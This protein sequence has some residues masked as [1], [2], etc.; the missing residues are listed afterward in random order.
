MPL[1]KLRVHNMQEEQIK[2]YAEFYKNYLLD[3][4][5]PFWSTHSVDWKHG[6]YF[7]CLDQKGHVYDTDKFIWLQARQAWTYSMLFNRVD[8]R[9][10]WLDIAE[11]GIQFLKNFGRDE[12]GQFYFSLTKEGTPLTY[13][14]NI[15]ADCF[16]ALAFAEHYKATGN[17][18]SKEIAVNTYNQFLKRKTNPKGKF[19]KSTGNRPMKSFGLS[20]MTAYL[21]V[22]LSDLIEGEQQNDIYEDCVHQILDVHYHPEHKVIYENVALDGSLLDTYDGR[23]INPGHGIEA[24]WFLMDLAKKLNRPEW[25]EKA[26]DICIELLEYGWDKKYGGIFYFMDSKKAPLQQLEWDQKLWWVHQEALIA[27]S[28][29]YLLTQRKDIWLW[30]QKVHDYAWSHFPDAENGEWF[31]YLNREGNPHL[32]LKGGKWKGCF[33]TPRAMY[34]CWK[35][36]EKLLK[37]P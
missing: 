33:H 28:K 13:S 19:E 24:M 6:G 16:A 22:E 26:S 12:Q 8:K 10:D 36:F 2:H 27:L 20:M 5:I 21:S 18:E 3:D 37:T 14:F 9:T 7:T 25:I 1:K 30:Y 4:V 34:E 15:Y 31:G 17:G 29:S 32:S 11:N 35:N 23:L